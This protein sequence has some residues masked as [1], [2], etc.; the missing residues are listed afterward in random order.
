MNHSARGADA[1]SPQSTAAARDAWSRYWAQGAPHS[2]VGSY[3][4]SYGGAIAEFWSDVFRTLP[5]AARVLDVATG[6][7][8]LPRLLLKDCPSANVSCDAVDIA[9][10]APTWLSAASPVDR[11]RVHFQGQVDAGLLP[12]SDSSFD[13]VIS[14]Y[15]FEYTDV[16]RTLPEVLRVLARA[17]SIALVLHHSGGRPVT[18]AGVE[19]AHL[20]WLMKLGGLFDGAAALLE[21][22]A[23]ASTA[24][25]RALLDGDPRAIAARERF[26]D[27]LSELA[28]RAE[29]VDGADILFDVRDAIMAVLAAVAGQGK[30]LAENRLLALRDDFTNAS[31]RL[32]DLMAHAVTAAAARALQSRLSEALNTSVGL[33]E[34]RE[35]GHLMGWTLRTPVP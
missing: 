27:L 26:N 32:R 11:G 35:Q 33:G 17:G 6:N 15:G 7:G 34:L 8:A 2:C 14:Q 16:E 19:L 24:Q 4:D 13:L 22:M 31:T 23:L 9:S 28:S 21:P 30:L 3:G 25:G 12:F 1:G 29:H 5:S 10:I 18:L 20:D